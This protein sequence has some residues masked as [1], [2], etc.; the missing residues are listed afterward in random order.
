M[1]APRPVVPSVRTM[2]RPPA[3]HRRCSSLPSSLCVVSLLLIVRR[4]CQRPARSF[5]LCVLCHDHRRATGGARH[6]PHHSVLSVSSLSCVVNASAPPGRSICAY[7]ATTT[8]APQEVLVTALITL[9]CQSPPY[10]AS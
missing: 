1:P 5:H 7:Y 10:R 3:R 2:P 4:E 9:C 6:C 8:G